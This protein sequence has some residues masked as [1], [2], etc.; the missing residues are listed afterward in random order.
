MGHPKEASLLKH[1]GQLK[2]VPLNLQGPNP[3]RSLASGQLGSSR[4]KSFKPILG[5]GL[6]MP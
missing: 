4:L 1:L 2:V 6:G 3:K 5:V